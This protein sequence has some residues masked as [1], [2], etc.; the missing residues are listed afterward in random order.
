MPKGKVKWFD[1]K[2]G[3]G[4]IV[5]DDGKDIFVHFSAIATDKSFKTLEDGIDVEYELIEDGKGMKASNV[6]AL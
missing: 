6:R 3:F 4:F 1:A 5:D 2:K